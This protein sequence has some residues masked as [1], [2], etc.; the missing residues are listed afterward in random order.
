MQVSTPLPGT[1]G[2]GWAMLSPW[3]ARALVRGA[4]A[5]GSSPG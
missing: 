3:A 2:V 1:A 5:G 4:A